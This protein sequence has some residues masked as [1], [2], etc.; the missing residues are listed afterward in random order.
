MAMLGKKLQDGE[1]ICRQGDA[2]DCMYAIQSGCVEA[3]RDDGGAL[4]V[5]GELTAG[6]FF[7]EMALFS[8]EAHPVTMRA[9][10]ETRV[11]VLDRAAFV[12][13]VQEDPSFAFRL[14]EKLAQHIR[15]LVTE[16]S[17]FK[18]AGS[19]AKATVDIRAKTVVE[20]SMAGW[21]LTADDTR[22]SLGIDPRSRRPS[23][24]RRLWFAL[25]AV[26]MFALGALLAI[27]AC[28][29]HWL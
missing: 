18:R 15:T 23:R 19:A 16:V 8:R 12:R 3:V 22:V 2:E 7:G 20:L 24:M 27:L 13:R 9:K 17:L 1:I 26:A 10:G 29:R 5:V 4:T 25:A 11:L 6:D 28:W 21:A 14:L